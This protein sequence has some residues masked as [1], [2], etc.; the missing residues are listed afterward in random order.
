MANANYH[1]N[2]A[3]AGAGFRQIYDSMLGNSRV[4]PKNLRGFLDDP[5]DTQAILYGYKRA[6]IWFR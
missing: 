6:V 4:Y 2:I 1:Q 5:R 3:V